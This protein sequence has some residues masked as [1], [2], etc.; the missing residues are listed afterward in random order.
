MDG[1]RNPLAEYLRDRRE[2]LDPESVGLP[3]EP[4]RRVSG[5]RRTEVAHLAGISADYYLRL[6][7][8]RGHQPSQ[9]VLSA[10][11]RALRLDHYGDEY[12]RR[13]AALAAG[14]AAPPIGREMPSGALDL[15]RLHRDTPAYV[16]NAT[17]DVVAVN[18]PGLLLAPGGLRPGMNLVMSVFGHYPDPHSE[19]HWDR[20]AR[21]LV[22][23]MRYHADPRDTRL[24]RIVAELSRTDARFR[25][26]W[27]A[28]SVGPQFNGW[29]MVYI[30]THGWVTLRA[31]SLTLAG[32]SG[33]TMTL[34]F[35]EPQTPGV[36][37][38]A[39]L[40][41]AANSAPPYGSAPE[42]VVVA[43]ELDPIGADAGA[44]AEE[45]AS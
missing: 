8:G 43:A 10:L 16:S 32:A 2:S 14:H 26:I 31:E 1:S 36:A 34:F 27:G 17:M 15:L 22:A 38:L 18:R 44:D 40:V 28:C 9:Q 23:S 25:R 39:D 29:P 35:A 20:T 13:M 5:L 3:V 4:G 21:A 33:W 19:A 6:E 12:L 45:L 42:A 41:R 24:R 30:D 11:S 7:Q 37:A